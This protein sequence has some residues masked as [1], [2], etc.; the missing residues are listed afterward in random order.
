VAVSAIPTP[1]E[2]RQAVPFAV[3]LQQPWNAG[4]VN[5]WN[6]HSS[7]N[8]S[9]RFQLQQGLD[10]AVQLAEHAKAHI[11]R[12]GNSSAVYRKWFGNR[13]T[14][15]ALGSYDIIINGDRADALFRCDDPDGNCAA[16][17][18]QYQLMVLSQ[19]NKY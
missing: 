6:I 10:E 18:S 15:E 8:G 9:E 19:D 2:E 17:P 16:M 1:V 14:V 11:A 4:A 3:T 7:C 13:P 12:W 5:E